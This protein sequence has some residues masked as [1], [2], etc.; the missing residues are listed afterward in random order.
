MELANGRILGADTIIRGCTLNILNHPFYIDL[1][2][3]ELGSFN[4]I[5]GMDWFAKY[6]VI[7]YDEKVICIP[8]RNKVL[9]IQG[10][11][12]D[13]GSNSRL[14]IISCIKTQKYIQIRCHVFLAQV[15]KKKAEDKSEEK[16]LEDMPIVQDFPKVFPEDLPGLSP[17]RQVEF[18]IDLVSGAAPVT[19]SPYRLASF[20]RQKL[21]T[22]LQELADKGFIR[23]T[24]SPWGALVL[25]FKKKDESF[26]MCIDYRFLKIAKP[27][28]KLTQMVV[29]FDWGEKEEATFQLLKQKL[30]SAPILALPERCE[31]FMVY[32]DA[33]YKGLGAV[34]MQREKVI[35]Y[36][37]R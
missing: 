4:V 21:S 1:K 22:Q 30:C 2:P 12:S 9:I 25:F 35:A 5:I 16:R 18:Q 34:L 15:T 19:R 14:S 3:V 11:G 33:S 36:A 29:K 17:T 37:S 20:E 7:V 24:S 31:N 8:Y 13:R 26:R 23:P 10:D 32:Y 28:T 27:M 6:H